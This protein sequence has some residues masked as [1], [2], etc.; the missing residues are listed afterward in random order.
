MPSAYLNLSETKLM[1]M[2]IKQH[3]N[4]PRARDLMSEFESDSKRRSG[5]M[6][7]RSSRRHDPMLVLN[8]ALFNFAGGWNRVLS[9][10]QYARFSV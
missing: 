5:K 2:R 1:E 7:Q 10:D 3:R 4:A 8:M 6:F 9:R